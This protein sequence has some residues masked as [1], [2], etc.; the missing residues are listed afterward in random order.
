M[1]IQELT[2]RIRKLQE[3]FS[4]K[5]ITHWIKNIDVKCHIFTIE[6]E[7]VKQL[8][9]IWESL[10]DK[11]A[12]YFQSTLENE[13]ETWNVY[14]VFLSTIKI[15]RKIKYEIENDKYSSRKIVIDEL[16][17]PIDESEI[18]KKISKKIFRL[19]I[20][21]EKPLENNRQ[22][23]SQ[24]LDPNLFSIISGVKLIGLTKPVRKKRKEV[25]EKLLRVFP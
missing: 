16:S 3:S 17:P 6:V 21:K 10:T 20:D 22:D 18:K 8:E 24:I 5:T 7:T 1:K 9:D 14:I 4:N 12:V 19:D 23:L 13:F 25:F 15:P 2:D 11:I